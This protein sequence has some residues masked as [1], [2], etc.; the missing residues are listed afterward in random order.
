M[1]WKENCFD[2]RTVV[3]NFHFGQESPLRAH[4]CKELILETKKYY[5]PDMCHDTSQFPDLHLYQKSDS[6]Q[7]NSS[8]QKEHGGISN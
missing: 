4:Q 6:G 3:Y 1:G 8:V 2:F 5:F 7:E